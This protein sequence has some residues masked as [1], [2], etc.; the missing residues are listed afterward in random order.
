MLRTAVI[1]D[2]LHV[3]QS[4]TDWSRLDGTATVEFFHDHLDTEDKAAQRLVSYDV[5]VTERERTHFTAALL[6][7]LPRLRLLVTTGTHNRYIDFAAAGRLGITVCK[8]EAIL[9]AAPE[10]AMGLMLALMRR[11]AVDNTAMHAGGW[12]TGL[13]RS[14]RGKTLGVVGLGVTGSQVVT[15][16]HAFGMKTVAWSPHM[17]QARA[18]AAGTRLASQEELLSGSDVVSLHMVLADSTR[19]LIG[20]R[21]LALMKPTAYLVN[22]S[23]GAL[24]DEAAL[25]EALRERRIAGAGLDVFAEEPLPDPHPLRA[26]DNVI[27]TPHTGYVTDEQYALCFGQAVEN[28]LAFAAGTPMRVMT[29]T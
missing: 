13:G 14:L 9:H 8:T 25:V 1:N 10:L 21:E 22:T 2:F 4:A 23:R 17:T 7:R 26:V 18:A 16:A 12:Q 29:H 27:L 15:L 24:V 28:I 11:I 6:E 19:G 5:V 20:R 3:F